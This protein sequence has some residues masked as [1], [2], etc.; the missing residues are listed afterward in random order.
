M[1]AD[2]DPIMSAGIF[3]P[4]TI[5]TKFA[6]YFPPSTSFSYILLRL[7]ELSIKHPRYHLCNLKDQTAIADSIQPVHNLTVHD[8]IVFCAS[9]ANPRGPGM[10]A[11]LQAFARCVGE[12]SSAALLDIPELDLD[13]LGQEIK[14]NR[15]YMERLES[16]HKALILYLWLSYRFA[17]VFVDQTM[18]FYVKRLVEEKIDKMLAEYSAS[19]AIR[20][21]IRMMRGEA[22]RQISKLSEPNE[23]IAESYDSEAHHKISEASLVLDSP[24]AHK[25][26]VGDEHVRMREQLRGIENE[27]QGRPIVASL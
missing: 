24:S 4:T 17:G 27:A 21:R 12:H 25:E 13:V 1:Q 7:H 23:P 18:A 5:L 14:V 20:E 3:P 9:P 8:R 6:A 11:V 22:L 2:L 16:L 15:L 26:D 19:P 10:R